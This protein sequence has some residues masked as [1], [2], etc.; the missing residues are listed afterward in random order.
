V[1]VSVKGHIRYGIN[2]Y[3]MLEVTEHEMDELIRKHGDSWEWPHRFCPE[4]RRVWPKPKWDAVVFYTED[5]S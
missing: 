5:K 4:T 2:T 1:G 3:L